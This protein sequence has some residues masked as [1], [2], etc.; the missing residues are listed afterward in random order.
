MV[1]HVA[2]SLP[3]MIRF[4]AKRAALFSPTFPL[5]S[6]VL[7]IALRE[8]EEGLALKWSAPVNDDIFVATTICSPVMVHQVLNFVH[9]PLVAQSCS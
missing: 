3:A 9:G 5:K 8:Q 7:Y 2:L 6:N 1:R 4:L